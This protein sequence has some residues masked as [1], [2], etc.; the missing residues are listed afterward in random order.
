[1]SGETPSRHDALSI[2]RDAR[3][4]LSALIGQLSDAELETSAAL[5]GGD[6]SV[7]DLIG[8][9]ASWEERALLWLDAPTSVDPSSYPAT[10]EFNAAEVDRKASWTLTHVQDHARTTHDGVL[11]AI[12]ST[13][14]E[15]WFADVRVPGRDD[16]VP[17][18]LVV[19]MILAGDEH[20]LFA[21]DLAH[22]AD[23]EMYVQQLRGGHASA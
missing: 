18:G 6:W 19:G 10:D 5:G 21:H 11:A 3:L 14:D 8:H 2:I 15:T 16:P 7:K 4:R 12:E 9:L 22:L 13:D 23:V 1:M 17:R 20:G